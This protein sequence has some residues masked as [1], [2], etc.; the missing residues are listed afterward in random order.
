MALSAYV[1]SRARA[2]IL[3]LLWAGAVALVDF[4]LIAVMLQW[5]IMQAPF[6][7]AALN[8]CGARGWR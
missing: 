1:T 8:R 4:A 6:F 3:V 7:L 2:A 5:L